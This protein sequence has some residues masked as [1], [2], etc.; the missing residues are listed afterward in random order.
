MDDV[1]IKLIIPMLEDSISQH[2]FRHEEAHQSIVKLAD[3][4]LYNYTDENGRNIRNGFCL[5]DDMTRYCK[6][7]VDGTVSPIT[8]TVIGDLISSIKVL[9]DK[10][11][12][13]E[14]ENKRLF[15][16]MEAYEDNLR[17]LRNKMK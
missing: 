12:K 5:K 3:T 16:R 8:Q 4:S 15:E 6:K 17:I 11:L 7:G 13:L 2:S 9:T 10:N 1:I 14:T